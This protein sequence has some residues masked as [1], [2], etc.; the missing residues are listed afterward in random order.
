MR[1]AM[2]LQKSSRF[3]NRVLRE[4]RALAAAGHDV[5]VV[6]L[7][8]PAPDRGGEPFALASAL[9]AG[10]VKRFVPFK[11]HRLVSGLSI[12][13][14]AA[15]LR[16]DVVHAH[17]VAMLPSSWLAARLAR[18][19]LVYDSH[20]YS[21]GVPWRSGAM[22]RLV[23]LVERLFVPRADAVVTVSDGIAARLAQRFRLRRAPLV[24]R[25]LPDL[26]GP[27]TGA[28]ELRRGLGIGD[29]GLVLHQGA[30]APH[31]GCETLIRAI[32]ALDGVH[33]VFLGEGEPPYMTALRLLAA[34]SERIHF[35]PARPPEALLAATAE[36]DVGV[37]LLEDVCENHRLA[38][39]NKV[40]EYVAAGVPVVASDLP[41]LRALVER[42]R[43]GWLVDPSDAASVAEGIRTALAERGDPQLRDALA[44]A[45][46]ELSWDAERPRLLELYDELGRSSG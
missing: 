4:A 19:R 16:P 43:I 13:R 14:R 3:D 1:V 30:P 21:A 46:R 42:Y 26:P 23:A 7:A 34:P 39:P 15:R 22:R 2:L 41:G 6:E 40:F 36:A 25:N 10:W 45:A 31:R 20:E 37:S 12:A 32:E 18:A 28:S 35:V 33:L 8:P 29:A 38:L 9:P 27:E 24:V 11:L 5:T 44:A 17:D